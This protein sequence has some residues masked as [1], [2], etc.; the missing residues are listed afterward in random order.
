MFAASYLISI[1]L[2]VGVLVSYSWLNTRLEAKLTPL[3]KHVEN[4]EL[5]SKLIERIQSGELRN[6]EYIEIFKAKYEHEKANYETDKALIELNSSFKEII[7]S[8][9]ALQLFFLTLYAIQ[10]KKT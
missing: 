7:A 3:A 1:F 6:E 4:T 8:V 10:K 5:Q 2:L 9:L